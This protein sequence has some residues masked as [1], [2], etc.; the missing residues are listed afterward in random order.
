MENGPW[1]VT[2]LWEGATGWSWGP[3][4][5][6]EHVLAMPGN[7]QTREL[8]LLKE[9]VFYLRRAWAGSLVSAS[10]VGRVATCDNVWLR[11][12]DLGKPPK[13]L[14]TPR[15]Q[16]RLADSWDGWRGDA[17]LPATLQHTVRGGKII[18]CCSL[19]AAWHLLQIVP[20]PN[21]ERCLS[22]MLHASPV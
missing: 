10:L 6:P 7:H 4:T 11:S 2:R 21:L 18:M 5:I 8:A 20:S 17:P 16:Q 12:L 15:C 22:W 13:T 3:Y 1:K 14:S 9:V 19:W